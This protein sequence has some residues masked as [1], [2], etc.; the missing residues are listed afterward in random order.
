M[1]GARDYQF[2]HTLT[3]WRED[4]PR[5]MYGKRSY[6]VEVMDCRY[7]ASERLYIGED[8]NHIRSKAVVYTKEDSL[9]MGDLVIQG[10]YS[11]SPD[12]VNG[13]YEIKIVRI[14]TNQRGT[15]QENRYIF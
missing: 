12:P 2:P 5:D 9:K 14:S 10:D 6:T 1:R 4:G 13:A 3:R 7:Q 15:R 11:S 8:G